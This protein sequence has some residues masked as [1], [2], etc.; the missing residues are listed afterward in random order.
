MIGLVSTDH[1]NVKGSAAL[2]RSLSNSLIISLCVESI[3]R[4]E[5]HYDI[6]FLRN[7]A[8]VDEFTNFETNVQYI[9]QCVTLCKFA[10]SHP[11]AI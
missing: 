3:G 7:G 4:D 1:A 8:E 9:T 11:F 5:P 10:Q 2:F 6:P